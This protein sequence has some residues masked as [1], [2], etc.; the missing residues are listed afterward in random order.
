M[1]SINNNNNNIDNYNKS[2]LLDNKLNSLCIKRLII[3]EI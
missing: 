3:P 1:I 2:I